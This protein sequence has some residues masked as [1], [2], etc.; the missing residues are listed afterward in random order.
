MTDHYTNWGTIDF[1]FQRLKSIRSQHF[2]QTST[3]PQFQ[4][5]YLAAMSFQEWSFVSWRSAVYGMA[6]YGQNPTPFDM[7]H[8]LHF[9]QHPRCIQYFSHQQY[10]IPFADPICWIF[11]RRRTLGTSPKML[12]SLVKLVKALAA[13][14][15]NQFWLPDTVPQAL[16]SL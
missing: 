5:W 1:T 8:C 16:A 2:S 3:I 12:Q 14:W 15:G 6:M 7:S 10:G 9:F 13:P 4:T 11:W